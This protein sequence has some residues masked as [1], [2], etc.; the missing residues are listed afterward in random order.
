LRAKHAVGLPRLREGGTFANSSRTVS[1]FLFLD[2]LECGDDD[3]SSI[4]AGT[5]TT[6]SASVK[7][8]SQDL[9]VREG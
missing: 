8:R 4:S 7:M 1:S 2:F 3:P 6:P 5:T 9:L